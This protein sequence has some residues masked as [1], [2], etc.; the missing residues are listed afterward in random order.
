MQIIGRR[1]KTS[2]L[3]PIEVEVCYTKVEVRVDFAVIMSLRRKYD[4]QDFRE[5]RRGRIKVIKT[6]VVRK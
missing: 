1:Q 5:M 6:S 2:E 3:H 4:A